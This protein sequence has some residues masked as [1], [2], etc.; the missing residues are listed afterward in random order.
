MVLRLS[1]RGPVSCLLP[2]GSLPSGR[3]KPPDG[4]SQG[5]RVRWRGIY[6][7]AVA[8]ARAASPDTALPADFSFMMAL[9]D[10]HTAVRFNLPLTVFVFNDNAVGQEKHDLVHK[11]LNPS[12]ADVPEPDFAKLETVMRPSKTLNSALAAV[13]G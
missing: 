2:W 6:R 10:F 3:S 11:N 7:G 1:R 4:K 5:P 12:Y 8:R 13:V 9:A